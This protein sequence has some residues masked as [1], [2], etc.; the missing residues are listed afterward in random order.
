MMM[1]KTKVSYIA[2][3]QMK[4][5]VIMNQTMKKGRGEM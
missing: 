3:V 5:K 1:R 2:V 4:M